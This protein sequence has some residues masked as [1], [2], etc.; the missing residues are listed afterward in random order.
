MTD[1]AILLGLPT[2]LAFIGVLVLFIQGVRG[3]RE[4]VRELFRREQ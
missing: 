4:H 1:L 2:S 3:R